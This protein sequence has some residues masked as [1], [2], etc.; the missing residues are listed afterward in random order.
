M[1]DYD[2]DF[3]VTAPLTHT[4]GFSGDLRSSSWQLSYFS[5][6]DRAK[7]L[8]GR[9]KGEKFGEFERAHHL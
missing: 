9:S 6:T 7:Y 1:T 4:Y 3:H 8:S 2:G 5:Q